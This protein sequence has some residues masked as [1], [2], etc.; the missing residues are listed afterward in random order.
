MIREFKKNGNR[1]FEIPNRCFSKREKRKDDSASFN[2]PTLWRKRAILQ[3][4]SHLTRSLRL[5]SI[6]VRFHPRFRTEASRRALRWK[7]VADSNR[8]GRR[9]EIKGEGSSSLVERVLWE[10]IINPLWRL[11]LSLSHNKLSFIYKPARGK[12]NKMI[13][14]YIWY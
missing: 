5:N 7:R 11:S 3:D 10:N 4:P 13:I 8:G 1:I 6:F 12:L 2:V 9:G 14:W